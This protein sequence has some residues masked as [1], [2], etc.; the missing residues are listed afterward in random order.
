MKK[1]MFDVFI[2]HASEDKEAFV[3][4]LA[5][6]LRKRG[7]KVWFDKFELKVGDSLRHRS[8]NKGTGRT[9]GCTPVLTE[10]P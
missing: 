10:V 9:Q 4:P 5:T 2:S 8:K 3:E 6:E 7:L 1:R